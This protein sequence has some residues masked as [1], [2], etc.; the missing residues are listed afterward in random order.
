MSCIKSS[1][2]GLVESTE[3]ILPYI[4]EPWKFQTLMEVNKE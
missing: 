2:T 1:R 4:A 3:R